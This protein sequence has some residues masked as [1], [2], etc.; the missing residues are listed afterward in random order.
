AIPQADPQQRQLP[1]GLGQPLA[2]SSRMQEHIVLVV[3]GDYVNNRDGVF[4]IND[5]PPSV[6]IHKL[7]VDADTGRAR[8]FVSVVC[9]KIWVLPH[10][11]YAPPG[12]SNGPG[13]GGGTSF[14]PKVICS[15]ARIIKSRVSG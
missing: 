1:A 12:K 8:K 4:V 13:A 14:S 5:R 2:R 10:H 11:C 3:A 9:Y 7:R 15:R 6:V